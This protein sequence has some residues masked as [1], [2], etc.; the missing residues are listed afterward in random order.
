MRIEYEC[1]GKK[2][3]KYDMEGSNGI[4]RQEIMDFDSGFQRKRSKYAVSKH[5]PNYIS[6]QFY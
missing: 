3:K 2:P 1:N 6:T 4:A 5:P